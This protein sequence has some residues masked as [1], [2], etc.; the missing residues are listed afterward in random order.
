MSPQKSGGELRNL[1]NAIGVSPITV[2]VRSGVSTST[3]YK[4]YNDDPSVRV[5]TRRKVIEALASL[6]REQGEAG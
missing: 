6:E 2:C 4:I 1:Q 5:A 3:L